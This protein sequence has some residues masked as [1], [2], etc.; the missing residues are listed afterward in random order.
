MFVTFVD[1]D[2][3]TVNPFHQYCTCIAGRRLP[4]IR[5]IACFIITVLSNGIWNPNSRESF[6]YIL[7]STYRLSI[8]KLET[9]I[10]YNV[11]EQANVYMQPV[12]RL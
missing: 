11:G 1:Y 12:L 5:D 9:Y 6:I 4:Q 10:L 3:E 7:E 2:V 8:R